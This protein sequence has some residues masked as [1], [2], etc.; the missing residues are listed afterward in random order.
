M[1]N[2][3]FGIL[4]AL[5]GSVAG[6]GGDFTG[7]AAVRRHNQFQV[8][9]LSTI[10]SVIL[11]AGLAWLLHEPLPPGL[12]WLW[13]SVGGM[14]L[15]MGLATLYRGLAT[16]HAAV[17]SPT[18]AVVGAAMPVVFGALVEGLPTPNQ[19]LAF[20][21]AFLGIWLV[22][23][24][25]AHTAAGH[26]RGVG[27][28]ILA[29]AALGIFFICIAQ[30]PV[31]NNAVLAPMAIA[32][33]ASLPLLMGL[34]AVKRLPLPGPQASP[35]SLLAGSLDATSAACFMMARQMTRL[36]I[37]AVLISLY[38]ATTVL[39][40]WAIYKERVSGSQWL[41]LALC[42]AAIALISA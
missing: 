1:F 6:G 8:M 16:G 31:N 40:S 30:V 25:N 10:A 12:T 27:L 20:G 24:P 18:S 7:G 35:M 39:L 19:A 2:A 29:G 38:P 23:R 42:I 11:L 9:A 37:A 28:G 5:A 32:K 22:A 33:L 21:L 3:T 4:F 15:A 36:D 13:A 34:L 14:S 26:S 17:V 41:G